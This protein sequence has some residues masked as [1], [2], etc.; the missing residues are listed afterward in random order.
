MAGEDS[1]FRV[2]GW[3]G[4]TAYLNQMFVS[5]QARVGSKV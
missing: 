4:G 1:R 5:Q 3:R 2:A